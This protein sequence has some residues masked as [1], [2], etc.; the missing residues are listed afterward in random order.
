MSLN[1][2]QFKINPKKFF[3]P[4][5]KYTEA[6]YACELNERIYCQKCLPDHAAHT[7]D[8]LPTIVQEIQSKLHTVRNAY[9][10]KK[11]TLAVKV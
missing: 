9:F 7:D 1:S 6:E 2:D 5:H 10:N 4:V 3:C 8:V 11:K